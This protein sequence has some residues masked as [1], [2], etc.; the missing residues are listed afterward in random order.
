MRPLQKA[1]AG[2]GDNMGVMIKAMVRA[3]HIETTMGDSMGVMIKAMA[4]TDHT[5]TT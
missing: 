4:N 1:I 5:E 2:I 3:D